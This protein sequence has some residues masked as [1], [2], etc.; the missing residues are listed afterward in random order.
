MRARGVRAGLVVVGALALAACGG[1]SSQSSG[2]SAGSSQ[3][4]LAECMRS[5]GV[6]NFPD[7]TK[8]P[9]GEGFSVTASPGSSAVTIDGIQ[10]N[11]P[12]FQSADRACHFL[13]GGSGPP[14]ITESQKEALFAKARC[15]REHGVPNFPDPTIGPGGHGIGIRLPPGVSPD[16]PAFRQ[17]ARACRAVGAPIPHVPT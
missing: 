14:T 8:G 5:H 6:P 11:G 7:P 9:G 12:V 3:L 2:S 10:F 13:S 15:L 4:A 16:S 17:A 1:G